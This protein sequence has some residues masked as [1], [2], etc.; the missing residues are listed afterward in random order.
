MQNA[1]ASYSEL[2]C[3]LVT[4]RTS[5]PLLIKCVTTLNATERLGN[6]EALWC[7][8]LV[9]IAK[10]STTASTS[11][12]ARHCLHYNLRRRHTLSLSTQQAEPSRHKHLSSGLCLPLDGWH[13]S[14]VHASLMSRRGLPCEV[15]LAAIRR[16]KAYC[17][18]HNLHSIT[19]NTS[20][21]Y[22]GGCK[23]GRA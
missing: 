10:S 11:Q 4:G 1:N 6:E 3:T 23:P 12:T 15:L 9:D 14:F 8:T 5:T 22:T 13:R 18:R 2:L 20:T 21:S 7:R 16:G 17:V 19:P